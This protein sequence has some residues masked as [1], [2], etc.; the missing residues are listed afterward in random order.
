MTRNEFMQLV[1][2]DSFQYALECF[3]EECRYVQRNGSPC[4]YDDV[5]YYRTDWH[6]IYGYKIT[7][8]DRITDIEDI[9]DLFDE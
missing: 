1:I 4:L 8:D 3:S 5:E 6:D 9:E 2:E 7:E